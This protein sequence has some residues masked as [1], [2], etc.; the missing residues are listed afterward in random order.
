MVG[1][2]E[3]SFLDAYIDK[4]DVL[5]YNIYSHASNEEWIADP[6]VG[7]RLKQLNKK[8]DNKTVLDTNYL[9]L[10]ADN[11]FYLKS[12][13]SIFLG[14]SLVY[15]AFSP[16]NL[17]TIPSYYQALVNF[18]CLNGGIGGHVLKQNFSFYFNYLS[19]INTKNIIV[20]LGFND[21]GNCLNGKSYNDIKLDIFQ[22]KINLIN[23][24]P[25]KEGLK[26]SLSAFLKILKLK[27]PIFQ[28]LRNKT[29]NQNF[30]EVNMFNYIKNLCR[31]IENF[32]ETYKDKK[33]YFFLQPNLVTSNKKLSPYENYVISLRQKEKKD[34]C[35]NFYSEINLKTR[36]IKNFYSLENVFDKN[37]D[38]I[39]I[40]EAHVADKGNEIIAKNIYNL[41]HNARD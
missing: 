35:R 30:S 27:K 15:G 23:Q 17:T 8:I 22:K 26:L 25:I 37:E 32:N 16:S 9:G 38:T 14:G 7:F 19:K 40:D 10:R 20:L 6:Y 11:E 2:K 1:K 21:M 33:I 24:R 29:K 31:D 4:I 5:K 28:L 34:F 12:Y 3:D 36:N 13:D 39:F 41:V 18:H